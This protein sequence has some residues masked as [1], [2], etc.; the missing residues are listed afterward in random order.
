M[1][2]QLYYPETGQAVDLKNRATCKRQLRIGQV[3]KFL[4]WAENKMRDESWTH[5]VV[6]GYEQQT[7]KFKRE[8]MVCAKALYSYNDSNLL[9]I[10][11]I[12]LPQKTRRKPKKSRPPAKRIRVRSI[13]ERQPSA[14]DRTEFGHC[15]IDTVQGK[16]SGDLALLT[17][18]E[19]NTRLHLLLPLRACCAEE[20]DKAVI[21]LTKPLGS[22]F[23]QVFKSI[24]ADNGTE[25]ISLDRSSL[26]FYFSHPSPSWDRGRNERHNGLTRRFIPKGKPFKSFSADHNRRSEHLMNNQTRKI[27]V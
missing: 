23:R 3:T 15:D 27:L 18:T 8:E 26:E 17:L 25:F 14:E 21:G 10:R 9:K 16:K 20:V 7:R 19:R 22:R 4:N 5:E 13:D 1:A 2:H 24:T 11:N 12:D 6:E